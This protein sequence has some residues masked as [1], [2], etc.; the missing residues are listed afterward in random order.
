MYMY[1]NIY[2]MYN[3]FWARC[4]IIFKLHNKKKLNRQAEAHYACQ[5][6]GNMAMG[7][8]LAS[9]MAVG[10]KVGV[11]MAMEME[12]EDGGDGDSPPSTLH[13]AIAKQRSFSGEG[14]DK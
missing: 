14:S 1:I 11:G 5:R 2:C 7:M 6:F 13:I 3:I 4:K 8:K 9:G 10:V 12:T